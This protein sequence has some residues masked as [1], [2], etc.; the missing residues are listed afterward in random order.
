M[1]Y[2]HKR[3]KKLY[4]VLHE[5]FDVE[6]QQ[7]HVVYLQLETGAIFN[8]NKDIFLSNFALEVA[9]PQGK[10]IPNDKRRK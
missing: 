1:I 10:I 9:D 3:T 7:S 6:T 8:R 5:S 2:R 4:S